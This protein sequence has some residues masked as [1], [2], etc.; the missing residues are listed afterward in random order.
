MSKKRI[1]KNKKEILRNLASS[2]RN[3]Q[4]LLD[5]V[6]MS[7]GDEEV[8]LNVLGALQQN[9][10]ESV[11]LAIMNVSKSLSVFKEILEMENLITSPTILRFLIKKVGC[12][13]Y[14]SCTIVFNLVQI[15]DKRGWLDE[16]DFQGMF[17][18]WEK[19]V[20]LRDILLPYLRDREFLL[21][22]AKTIKGYTEALDIMENMAKNRLGYEDVFV[23]LWN[24]RY[25]KYVL[26][27]LLVRSQEFPIKFF[28]I[29]AKS[30]EN[31]SMEKEL[32]RMLGVR[33]QQEREFWQGI[34]GD[35]FEKVKAMIRRG[36]VSE[37]E[38]LFKI[39]Y[40]FRNV[41]VLGE[42]AVNPRTPRKILRKLV[43]LDM[44]EI[45]MKLAENSN[46]PESI[47]RLIFERRVLNKG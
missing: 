38:R 13:D 22:A 45:D 17:P 14:K 36:F 6:F 43:E 37:I 44:E 10:N 26:E 46:L 8:L 40:S 29:A 31:T 5:I 15:A 7:K 4:F 28:S 42:I 27:T 2:V 9:P 11:L 24:S 21:K 35:R 20:Y 39:Y 30:C 3:P 34:K 47:A 12:K 19:D 23:V 18:K 41:E 25:R 16:I 1:N 33:R 32:K